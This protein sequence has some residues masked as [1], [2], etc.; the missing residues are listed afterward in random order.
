MTIMKLTHCI[1][2]DI[3]FT[4]YTIEEYAQQQVHYGLDNSPVYSIRGCCDDS[5]EILGH[6]Y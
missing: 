3:V 2:R 5:Y 4:T 6:K 1:V